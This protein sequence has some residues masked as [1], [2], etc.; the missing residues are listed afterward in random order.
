MPIE[1]VRT[2]LAMFM[3]CVY[4]GFGSVRR[5]Q[6]FFGPVNADDLAHFSRKRLHPAFPIS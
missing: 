3:D 6:H 4:L 5:A 1:Q 2:V